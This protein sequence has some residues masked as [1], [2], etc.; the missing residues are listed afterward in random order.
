MVNQTQVRRWYQAI[1]TGCLTEKGSMSRLM[2]WL[3]PAQTFLLIPKTWNFQILDLND[4]EVNK[5]DIQ[6]F[7]ISNHNSAVDKSFP[8]NKNLHLTTLKE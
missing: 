6:L 4:K 5:E 8:G 3:S 1:D 2:V 7:Y